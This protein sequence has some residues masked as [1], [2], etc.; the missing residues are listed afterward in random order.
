MRDGNRYGFTLIEL[1]IVI[2][3][4]GIL[5]AL[6]LPVLS[7]AKDRARRTACLN[8]LRQ[9]NLGIRMY[10]DDA[11]DILPSMGQ[12]SSVGRTNHIL[13]Y[14]KILMQGYVGL[15]GPPSP[16]DKIFTCP[17]DTC[18]YSNG[19]Y[20]PKSRHDQPWS[21]YTSYWFNGINS[22][23]NVPVRNADGSL[24]GISGQKLSSIKHPTRTV[25]VAEF[26]AYCPYSWHQPQR[27]VS[28]PEHIYFNNALDMVSFVDGHVSYIKMYWD[29]RTIT[30]VY[31]P[32]AGFDY[33]WSGD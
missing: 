10:S 17:A 7:A 26:P 31:D 2:V 24:P 15:N 20:V 4:I 12:S 19:V 29:T 21:L 33:Q 5:A 11:N 18:Y 28:N 32:P 22:F 23:T 25:L 9:V 14:Y 1:L 30:L 6:L 27:P 3:I 16:Q 8:N 13:V